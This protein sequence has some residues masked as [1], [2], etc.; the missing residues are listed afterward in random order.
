MYQ[1]STGAGIVPN[2]DRM[3]TGNF[4]GFLP[5]VGFLDRNEAGLM[6][7]DEA[8]GLVLEYV[9]VYVLVDSFP[10]RQTP[11]HGLQNST[12]IVTS[13]NHR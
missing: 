1:E 9:H 11:Q 8:D 4:T 10:T 13:P 3:M 6:F 5:A 7:D 2:A 12:V